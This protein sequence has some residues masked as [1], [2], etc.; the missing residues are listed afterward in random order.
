MDDLLSELNRFGFFHLN[1]SSIPSVYGCG[2]DY[3]SIFELIQRGQAVSSRLI[4]NKLTFISIE[5]YWC[6]KSIIGEKT[7]NTT[8]QQ[9]IYDLLQQNT[10]IETGLLR[11][12]CS[13]EKKCFEI[14]LNKLHEKLLV[15]IYDGGRKLNEHWYTYS[16]CTYKVIESRTEKLKVKDCE[17]KISEKLYTLINAKRADNIINKIIKND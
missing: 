2:Y 5:M 11:E 16:W 10:H 12:L 6:I 9:L 13:I 8:E 3:K 1:K 15:S 17:K 14:S 7:R 4:D